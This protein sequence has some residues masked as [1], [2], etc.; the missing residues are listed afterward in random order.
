MFFANPGVHSEVENMRLW[1]DARVYGRP[2]HRFTRGIEKKGPAEK[3][4]S[5]KWLPYWKQLL[6]IVPDSYLEHI[7]E[8]NFFKTGTRRIRLNPILRTYL[9][10]YVLSFLF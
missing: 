4:M 6:F 3:C 1:R 5:A 10:K 2:S 9:N 7:F 8:K